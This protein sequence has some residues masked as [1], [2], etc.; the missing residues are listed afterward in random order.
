MSQY[1]ENRNN[2]TKRMKE[3]SVLLL[4][5]GK[6]PHKTTDQYYE[7]TVHK[8]FYYLTGIIEE[9]CKLMILKDG[10][11]SHTYLF[12]PETTEHMRLW[13]G[14]KISKEEASKIS[15]IDV[16]NIFFTKQ[17]LPFFHRI[18]S[19]TRGNN[20]QVPT[21]VYLDLLRIKPDVEPISYTQFRDV[22]NTYKELGVLNANEHLSYIRMFKNKQEI[23]EMEHAIEITHKGINRVMKSAKQR[24]YEN[25]LEA[26][27]NHELA[28]NGAKRT[29]FNTIMASGVNATVLHYEDNNSKLNDGDLVL[30]DLGAEWNNYAADISRTFPINGTFTDRQ[31][32]I[33]EIVLKANKETIE[34]LKPGVTWGE[35]NK[36]ARDILIKECKEIGLIEEDNDILKYYY[37]SIGHFLG[38][39]T[40]DIGHYKEP[41]QEGMVVTVEPGL[42]IKEEGIGIRIEDDILIT[43]DGHINLSKDIIKEVDD[44]EA[45]MKK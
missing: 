28:L 6:A 26:D 22:L 7:Y 40:H 1:I 31:K 36:F 13:E 4:D 37:H 11:L 5:S 14:E 27:F 44:I 42:Y 24:E 8:S 41:L 32:Q 43:K 10:D 18:M 35:F 12:I 38:L 23:K 34:M 20:V 29:S 33:Y 15:G 19:Y 3:A 21:Q 2:L 17:F 30:L 25:Q 9:E 45:F 39:D 16:K